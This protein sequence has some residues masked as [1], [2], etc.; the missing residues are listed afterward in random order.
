MTERWFRFYDGVP[1]DPKILRLSDKLYRLW[2]YL[3]C[4]ASANGGLVPEL[5]DL[6]LMLRVKAEKLASDLRALM[7]AGLF[8]EVDASTLRPHNWNGRQFKSDVSTERVKRFRERH[9]NVSFAVSETPPDTESE[10][11]TEQKKETSLRSGKKNGADAPPD[12]NGHAKPRGTR[13]PEGFEPLEEDVA[14]AKRDGLSDDEIKHEHSKFTD[15]WR[16]KA[17][18]DA[19]K[20]DWDA[21]WRNWMRKAADDKRNRTQRQKSFLEKE[22]KPYQRPRV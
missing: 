16:A 20:V 1:H 2:T 17:G 4:F 12:A 6:A 3:L 11:D 19:T 21:T 18:K 5:D 10:T 9:G 14:A 22:G 13:I 8:D 7:E 15:Y